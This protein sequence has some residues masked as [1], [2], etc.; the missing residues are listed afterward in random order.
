MRKASFL[1]LP[2]LWY[3][4]F[5]IVAIDAFACSLPVIAS[6]IGS[7]EDIN[8]DGVTGLEFR[9]ADADDLAEKVRW[10]ISHPS[11]MQQY[12]RNGRKIYEERYSSVVNYRA[13]MKIYQDV[14]CGRKTI[15][16]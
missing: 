2:S 9:A 8:I 16:G 15:A 10:A 6:K 4:M 11:E 3:E 7:I 5:P 12:G 13:L 14:I 1:I